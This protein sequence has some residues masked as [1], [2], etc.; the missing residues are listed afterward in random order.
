MVTLVELHILYGDGRHLQK[1]SYSLQHSTVLQKALHSKYSD[2]PNENLV[3][4]IQ[5]LRLVHQKVHLFQDNDPKHS[6]RVA[7][8]QLCECHWVAQPESGL[9]PNQIFLEKPENA[10]PT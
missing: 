2:S 7:Y 8:R 10:Y 1:D 9:E 5:N 4:S 6:A 3:Q